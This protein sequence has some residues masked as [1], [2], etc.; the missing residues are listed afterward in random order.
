MPMSSYRGLPRLKSGSKGTLSALE[1][2]VIEIIDIS[3][4]IWCPCM[5]D[6]RPNW[7]LSRIEQSLSDMCGFINNHL[8]L[9][10]DLLPVLKFD[11]CINGCF[12]ECESCVSDD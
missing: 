7:P 9:D 10:S 8:P 1:F 3:P 11:F 2:T 4:S 6:I 12:P 5:P